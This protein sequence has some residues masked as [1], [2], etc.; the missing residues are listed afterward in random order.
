[1]QPPA[2]HNRPAAVTLSL[3]QGI[4]GEV[5]QTRAA[6]RIRDARGDSEHDTTFLKEFGFRGCYALPLA[7]MGKLEGVLK[8]FTYEP[9]GLDD[10][11][12]VF[13]EAVS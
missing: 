1:M 8:S 5:A 13:A 6:V 3:G 4:A 12:Q 2:S 7:S 11:A 10:D 9:L